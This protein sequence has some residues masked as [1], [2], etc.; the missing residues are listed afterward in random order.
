VA[1]FSLDS[2]FFFFEFVSVNGGLS[3]N[4]FSSNRGLWAPRN[5]FS[6]IER[7]GFPSAIFPLSTRSRFCPL[8]DNSPVPFLFLDGFGLSLLC[9][10]ISFLVHLGMEG[11]RFQFTLLDSKWHPPPGGLILLAL[12]LFYPTPPPTS[13]P[14]LFP[15]F[16]MSL[17]P[18]GA[19]LII[20]CDPPVPS[21][22]MFSPLFHHST[23]FPSHTRRQLQFPSS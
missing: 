9:V 13:P 20:P 21:P 15:H 5:L 6:N 11:P 14:H 12:K 3:G 7:D 17:H 22:L 2:F 10:M 18:S 8:Y 1:V 19:S 23:Y 4:R 16:L